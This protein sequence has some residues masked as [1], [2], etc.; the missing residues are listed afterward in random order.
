MRYSLGKFCISDLLRNLPHEFCWY[1]GSL[2]FVVVGC[3]R[4]LCVVAGCSRLLQ[5]VV[6]C[7]GLYHFV[8]LVFPFFSDTES[9]L[10]IGLGCAMY[11]LTWDFLRSFPL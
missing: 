10:G 3:C 9:A 8:H 6:S 4:L 11:N 2:R 1:S 5:V 7:C